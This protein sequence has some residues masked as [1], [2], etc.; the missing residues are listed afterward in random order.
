MSTDIQIS[1]K[2]E[3]EFWHK[4][5][6]F[7]HHINYKLLRYYV[8]GLSNAIGLFTLT[9]VLETIKRTSKGLTNTNIRQLENLTISL[10]SEPWCGTVTGVVM[11]HITGPHVTWQSALRRADIVLA[12]PC[13]MCR[14]HLD[15]CHGDRTTINIQHGAR[16]SGSGP[17]PRDTTVSHTWLAISVSGGTLIV[18]SFDTNLSISWRLSDLCWN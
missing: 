15:G 2:G 4:R 17:D 14:V 3:Q 11:C 7:C 16:G 12:T 10:C 6:F 13:A 9:Y 18:R 5:S 1:L 8:H